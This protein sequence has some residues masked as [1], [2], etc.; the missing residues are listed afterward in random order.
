MLTYFEPQADFHPGQDSAEGFEPT[1]AGQDVYI[2][3]SI[4]FVPATV[5]DE[6]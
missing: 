4:N 5:D 1:P 3:P 2:H 6:D